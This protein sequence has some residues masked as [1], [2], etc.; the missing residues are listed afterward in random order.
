[1]IESKGTH[2]VSVLVGHTEE[3][4]KEMMLDLGMGTGF[5][6][7]K[8]DRAFYYGHQLELLGVIKGGRPPYIMLKF[9]HPFQVQ[10]KHS[11]LFQENGGS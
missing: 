11:E 7:E 9:T 8:G 2:Q 1:M 5:L 4:L 10:F 3:D 6:D